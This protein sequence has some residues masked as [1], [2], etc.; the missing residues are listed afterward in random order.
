MPPGEGIL[1]A[2]A[3]WPMIF[4]ATGNETHLHCHFIVALK[5]G[6]PAEVHTQFEQAFV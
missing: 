6:A 3:K 1:K 4:G 2:K 5:R